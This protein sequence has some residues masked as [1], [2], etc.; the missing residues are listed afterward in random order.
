MAGWVSASGPNCT[1][2]TPT[3][4]EVCNRWRPCT[5]RWQAATGPPRYRND[6]RGSG[7]ESLPDTAFRSLPGPRRRNAGSSPAREP[8]SVHPRPPECGGTPVDRSGGH[9]CCLALAA[10]NAASSSRRN[11]SAS[12]CRRSFS[13]RSRA[14][15]CRARSRSRFGTNSMLSD[16][17]CAAGWL[18]GF[19]QPNGS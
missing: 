8:R 1:L 13:F 4:S 3:A 14:I 6:A 10:R 7:E 11:R 19:I 18:I 12:Y 2:P 15:S 5:R 16:C 9:A 17:Q